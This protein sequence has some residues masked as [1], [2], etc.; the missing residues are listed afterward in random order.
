MK[1]KKK[2]RKLFT[3]RAKNR[4]IFS[5]YH[6]MRTAAG[7]VLT[8]AAAAVLGVVGYNIVGPVVIRMEAEAES[9][10]TTPDPYVFETVPAETTALPVQTAASEQTA[11]TSAVQ[12]TVQTTTTQPVSKRFP[13]GLTVA[14]PAPEDALT[15]L[16]TLDAAAE[17]MEQE[18]YSA[19]ILP[20][21]MNG[22]MLSFSS[23][24]QNARAC[25][26]CNADMLTVREI[27]NAANRRH[28]QCVALFS[29]LED[30]IYPGYFT[31]ASYT[32]KDGTTRW[33]DGKEAEGGKPW[34]NP[35]SDA[36]KAYLSGL[37]GEL[38]DGGFSQILCTDAVFPFFYQTDIEY[39]GGHVSDNVR[40]ADALTGMLNS[41][42]GAAPE[43]CI[44]SD[45]WDIIT[46]KEEAF[47]PDA[48][49]TGLCV[50][51]DIKKF[52][53]P[54]IAAGE[55]FDPSSLAYADRVTMLLQAVREVAGGMK[56]YPNI[57]TGDLTDEETDI[58]V[59][60][61]ADAG[62]DTVFLTEE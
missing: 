23:S 34:L 42:A 24:D 7:V 50:K 27:R 43:A 54:F 25:G 59:Q 5:P 30:H 40:R 61:V 13:E 3:Y 9:P 4:R 11:A 20:M 19:M 51:I 8:L 52:E 55:R 21:K 57:V 35:F 17:K 45:L 37:A 41:I 53:Q 1:K 38:H 28:L 58:A 39:I 6:P 44:Y 14:A 12:T 49:K 47:R 16:D 60:A 15:D 62:F 33:L 56:C 46:G 18:G 36:A 29:T 32:F 48:L 2:G 26:A 31:E 22:G 10:T